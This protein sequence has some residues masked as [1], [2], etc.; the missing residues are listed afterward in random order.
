MDDASAKTSLGT[1][2]I[3]VLI[4]AVAA[5]VLIKILIGTVIAIAWTAAAI[6][7]VLAILWA[8]NKLL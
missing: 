8:V 4:L 1:R 5:W 3:A 2:V 7:A 6:V